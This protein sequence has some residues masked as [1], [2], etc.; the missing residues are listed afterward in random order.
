MSKKHA[1]PTPEPVL[2]TVAETGKTDPTPAKAVEPPKA[3][4]AD[5]R[6]AIERAEVIL[7]DV[8]AASP[9]ERHVVIA[10][11]MRHLQL[12]RSCLEGL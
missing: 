1:K 3:T 5:V 8:S 11:A 9:P 10:Q 4:V 6:V 7:G 2:A 12:S